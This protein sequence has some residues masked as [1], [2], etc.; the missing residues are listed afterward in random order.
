LPGRTN[1]CSR[2]AAASLVSHGTR[3]VVPGPESSDTRGRFAREMDVG[4]GRICDRWRLRCRRG[5]AASCPHPAA[6]TLPSLQCR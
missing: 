6:L 5:S 2:Q 1:R 3:A 4:N